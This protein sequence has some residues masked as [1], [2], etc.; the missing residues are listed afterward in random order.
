MFWLD[1]LAIKKRVFVDCKKRRKIMYPIIFNSSFMSSSTTLETVYIG[2]QWFKLII[3][4]EHN[5]LRI[6]CDE[7]LTI[8]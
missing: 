8:L 4:V 7:S 3:N 1:K 5:G 2:S 6:K